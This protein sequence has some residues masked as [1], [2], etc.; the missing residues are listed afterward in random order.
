MIQRFTLLILLLVQMTG[1]QA[2]SVF[3]KGSW[4][5]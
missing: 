1:T 4:Y 2:Q 3:S 5:Q